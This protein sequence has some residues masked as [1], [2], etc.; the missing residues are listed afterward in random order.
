MHEAS[1]AQCIIE[2]LERRIEEGEIA[3]RIRGV[4]LAV[5]RLTA[6]FPDNLRFLF[7]VL[8]KGSALE[9]ARLDIEQVPILARCM[10][11]GTHFEIEDV[12]FSC[13]GCGSPDVDVLRG[14][15]L[16]IESVE[17]D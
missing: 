1:L 4:Y 10:S 14:S 17:V 13:T 7:Q 9:G 8:A 5:G 16:Q 15:E 6:V 11:C 2:D 12:Y 3:G